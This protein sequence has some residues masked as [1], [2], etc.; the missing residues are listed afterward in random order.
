MTEPSGWR[1]R[2]TAIVLAAFGVPL[3]T[4]VG[5]FLFFN[6]LAWGT[7]TTIEASWTAWGVVGCA[8][9][10]FKSWLLAG[11]L[12]S[13]DELGR[14]WRYRLGAW[15]TLANALG[16]F[17]AFA[18]WTVVGFLS[19]QVPSAPSVAGVARLPIALISGSLFMSVE[20]VLIGVVTFGLI[21]R[22]R[23]AE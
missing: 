18:V 11:D 21:A 8:L 17:F 22:V 2:D 23:L 14:S 10:A 13:V 19:G 4:S 7:W 3:L 5:A 1:W 6:E 20:A 16:L 9:T 15:W 12:R